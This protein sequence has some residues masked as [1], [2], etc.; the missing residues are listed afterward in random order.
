M[1]KNSVVSNTA[2]DDYSHRAICHVRIKYDRG[3]EHIFIEHLSLENLQTLDSFVN[4]NTNHS[5]VN[6][7]SANSSNS[8][9]NSS[10]TIPFYCR[11]RLSPEKRGLFQTKIVR[12]TR[13]QSTF[14]FDGKQLNDFELSYDQLSNHSIEMILYRVGTNKPA[15]KDIRIATVKFDLAALNEIDQ[16]SV[17]KPLEEPDAF[18]SIQVNINPWFIIILTF[19]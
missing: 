2:D 6:S 17:K 13:S 5:H 18:S 12:C 14:I 19:F 3:S 9:G 1:Q 4:N 11:F 7:S 16:I 8:S 10:D 15:Y